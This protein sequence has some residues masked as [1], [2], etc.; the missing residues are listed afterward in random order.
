MSSWVGQYILKHHNFFV[1][2]VMPM[3]VGDRTILTPE[4]MAHYRN[5]LPSPDERTAMAA[6][7][8]HIVGASDWLRS[9]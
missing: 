3:A 6:F 9:V 7:P 1:R 4:I 5:A 8:G 2:S